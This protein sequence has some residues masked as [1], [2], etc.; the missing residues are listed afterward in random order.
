MHHL[1]NYAK[2]MQQPLELILTF[3]KRYL[4]QIALLCLKKKYFFQYYYRKVKPRTSKEGD[5][6]Y[7]HIPDR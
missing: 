2:R 7:K 6:R 4:D 1:L 3:F 5:Q